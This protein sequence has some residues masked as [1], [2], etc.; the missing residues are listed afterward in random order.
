MAKLNYWMVLIEY[1]YTEWKEVVLDKTY[2]L[3]QLGYKQ[4]NSCGK[5]LHYNYDKTKDEQ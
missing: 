1:S 2:F 5:I 3:H 4:E